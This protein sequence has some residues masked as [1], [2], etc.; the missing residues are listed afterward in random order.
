MNTFKKPFNPNMRKSF[1]SIIAPE[2]VQ[3]TEK[4]AQLFS[5]VEQGNIAEVKKFVLT[6]RIKLSSKFNDSTV[7]HKVLE[8]DDLKMPEL[9]KLEFI[10]Y[11][12]SNGAHVN[13]YDKFNVTPLHMAVQARYPSIVQYLISKGANINSQTS[14][15]LTPLHYATL[16]NIQPC[17]SENMPQDLIPKPETKTIDYNKPIKE[18]IKA[19]TNNQS[20]YLE[21]NNKIASYDEN[22]QP[23][24]NKST[25]ILLNPADNSGNILDS[26]NTVIKTISNLFKYKNGFIEK[27]EE[28]IRKTIEDKKSDLKTL[29]IK[30]ILSDFAKNMTSSL[31]K[32]F[33]IN[34]INPGDP[35]LKKVDKDVINQQEDDLNQQ[36]VEIHNKTIQMINKVIGEQLVKMIKATVDKNYNTLIIDP[37]TY[38]E[39]IKDNGLK[40]TQFFNSNALVVNVQE[41]G[42]NFILT[43]GRTNYTVNKKIKLP[44]GNINFPNQPTLLNIY[45]GIKYYISQANSSPNPK[46]V[47]PTILFKINNFINNIKTQHSLS[48]E[49]KIDLSDFIEE[50]K[51]FHLNSINFAINNFADENKNY[52]MDFGNFDNILYKSYGY[53]FGK[54]NFN[55]IKYTGVFTDDA[56]GQNNKKKY[57]SSL[58]NHSLIKSII[59]SHLEQVR[60]HYIFVTQPYYISAFNLISTTIPNKLKHDNL[61]LIIYSTYQ[62]LILDNINNIIDITIKKIISEA[63]SKIIDIQVLQELDFSKEI[64]LYLPSFEYSFGFSSFSK[65][66]V[67]EIEANG[68]PDELYFQTNDYKV[69]SNLDLELVEQ[70]DYDINKDLLTIGIKTN[71]LYP[72]FHSY[73]YDTKDSNFDCVIIDPVI[74]EMLI[75]KADIN[76]K[77]HT[78]K[79]II[80]YIIEGKMHYLLDS[81]IIKS[82]LVSRNIQSVISKCI[83]AEKAH[84]KLLGYSNNK[85][86]FIENFVNNYISK[87]KNTQEVKSNIPINSKNIFKAYL[88]IQNI[89]WYRLCNKKFHLNSEY[90]NMFNLKYDYNSKLETTS[91]WKKIF[92][93]IKFSVEKSSTNVAR[94]E[95]FQTK[96]T[97]S[98]DKN[99]GVSTEEKVKQKKEK[100]DLLKKIL[101]KIPKSEGSIQIELRDLNKNS[102]VDLPEDKTLK[103]FR[104]IFAKIHDL[105]LSNS[106]KQDPINEIPPI[107]YTYAWKGLMDFNQ[108]YF[109]HLQMS[110][111]LD[112]LF[113]QDI[114]IPTSQ[115]ITITIN[116]NQKTFDKEKYEKIKKTINEID[117]FIEPISEFVDG[118]LLTKTLSLNPILLFQ[119]RTIV[120][121]LTS[122]IGSNMYMFIQKLLIED[123]KSRSKTPTNYEPTFRDVTL[124][125][126]PLKEYILSDN[127]DT[128]YLTFA[129][130]KQSMGFEVS[131]IEETPET[132]FDDIFEKITK[133]LPLKSDDVIV[134]KIRTNVIPY[135]TVLYKE[136]LDS[137]INFS[138]SYYRFVK[139]Q[140]LGIL[141]LKKILD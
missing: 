84:N 33:S 20:R 96:R 43:L 87:L 37:D 32:E 114:F 65:N 25:A 135:Y 100:L 56:E 58:I 29:E 2:I 57:F 140:H 97:E 112:D 124:E 66:L 77:D 17:P 16:M 48:N 90:L 99:P 113:T 120:H 52:N 44:L 1:T 106:P 7:L 125:L 54:Y 30:E 83:L 22:G 11:L 63:A 42:N 64:E 115:N 129:F 27:I 137:L 69:K 118:R 102:E 67:K 93:N 35:N 6:S 10:E 23:L 47:R 13:S 86:I 8:I 81:P 128:K 41:I 3:D 136:T 12:I 73:N 111:V 117:K 34:S 105:D 50:I 75:K 132:S 126:K 119:V 24:D 70:E 76:I 39:V 116:T 89:Y 80:D 38:L 68:F 36:F 131:K 130:I 5:L 88:C 139:N 49:L 101:E 133:L 92:D 94:R 110:K 53:I 21:T 62:K 85:I 46:K 95:G 121:L 141:T 98:I 71:K 55:P 91:D 51:N 127:L 45:L 104:S 15:S 28:N 74:I 4:I 31:R 82:R 26:I 123:K 40:S 14:E 78:G 72:I 103:Y 59:G 60:S 122:F 108:N 61:R 18:I 9:K 109:I 138:D 107:I 134:E 79:T 19:F